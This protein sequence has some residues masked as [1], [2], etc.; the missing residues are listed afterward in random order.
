MTIMAKQETKEATTW[1][2]KM[3]EFGGG[4]FTFLSTDGETLI[5]I[6]VG[7]PV[8][9]KGAYKGKAQER[10]G[11]PIVTDEGFQLLVCG[12]RLARQLSKHEKIFKTHALMVTRVGIEGDVNSKYPVRVLPEQETFTKLQIIASEDFSP[13]MIPD[14]VEAALKVL[15]G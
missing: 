11:C 13:D 9:M 5:F 7:L 1:G 2:G 15:Q 4:S 6:V 10:I 3:Q 12:K 8:L 14:A